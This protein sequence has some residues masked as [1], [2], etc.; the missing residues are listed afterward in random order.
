MAET[1]LLAKG[2]EAHKRIAA[3]GSSATSMV[4]ETYG[5]L[6]RVSIEPGM[7]WEGYKKMVVNADGYGVVYLIGEKLYRQ[8]VKDF[9]LDELMSAYARAGKSTK[10]WRTILKVEYN[11]ICGLCV[12]WYLHLGATAAELALFYSNNKELV[13]TAIKGTKTVYNTLNWFKKN[14]PTLYT[15]LRNS[16]AWAVAKDMPSEMVEAGT[17]AFF[18]GRILMNAKQA[19]GDGVEMAFI[20]WVKI[21]FKVAALVVVTHMPSFIAHAAAKATKDVVEEIRKQLGY[22]GVTI[23]KEEAQQMIKELTKDKPE[24]EK[25]LKELKDQSERYL[26]VIKDVVKKMEEENE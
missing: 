24:T 6:G 12:P 3:L 2:E 20:V 21:I 19:I 18:L 26:P 13:D 23:T 9:I 5:L 7:L 25:K 22:E 15:K 16:A 17:V 11:F 8:S 4:V 14:C 1:E 10:P